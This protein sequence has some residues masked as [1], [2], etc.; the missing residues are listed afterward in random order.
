MADFLRDRGFDVKSIGNAETW[1]YPFTLVVSRTKDRTIA[2][3]I[4][5]A[6]ATDKQIVLRDG[7][8]M[9][10]ATVILGPDFAE[11]IE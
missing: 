8:Q 11:R 6:L 9:Y 2:N 4:C 5:E 7:E 1:N 3:Q 10:D